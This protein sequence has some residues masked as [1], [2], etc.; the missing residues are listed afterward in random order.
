[1]ILNNFFI[2][3]NCNMLPACP[4][5]AQPQS[6]PVGTGCQTSP[7][8][9]GADTGHG[10]PAQGTGGSINN[11]TCLSQLYRLLKTSIQP[12][13]FSKRIVK[14]SSYTIASEEQLNTSLCNSVEVSLSQYTIRSL[15]SIKRVKFT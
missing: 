1:M 13:T 14:I 11:M 5:L 6:P 10:T 3:I 9:T 8:M 7:R 15:Q 2:N 4:P 12:K